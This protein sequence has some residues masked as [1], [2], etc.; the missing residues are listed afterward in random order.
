MTDNV[1]GQAA[2]RI[3]NVGSYRLLAV[4]VIRYRAMKVINSW[5]QRK[6]SEELA[7]RG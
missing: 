6:F 7:V 2:L 5:K 4:L 3:D 1:Y